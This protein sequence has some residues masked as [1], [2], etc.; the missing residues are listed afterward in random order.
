[1]GRTRRERERELPNRT[2][3]GARP[4][5]MAPNREGWERSPHPH[6]PPTLT[7]PA[8]PTDGTFRR[9]G[10]ASL[11]APGAEQRDGQ[12]LW[13]TQRQGSR[14]LRLASPHSCSVHECFGLGWERR[15]PGAAWLSRGRQGGSTLREERGCWSSRGGAEGLLPWEGACWPIPVEPSG[16]PGVQKSCARWK[17]VVCHA[18]KRGERGN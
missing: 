3:L 18:E 2:L 13:N 16:P 4:A 5:L 1:M 9:Q 10:Q 7:A 11:P 8:Q 14:C 15:D 6:H 17:C 12:L